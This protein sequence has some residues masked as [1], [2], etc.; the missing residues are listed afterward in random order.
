M[1][2]ISG[3]NVK[4][5]ISHLASA[6]L[7]VFEHHIVQ[8]SDFY[9]DILRNNW[10]NK[11]IKEYIPVFEWERSNFLIRIHFSLDLE[12]MKI[13]WMQQQECLEWE[14]KR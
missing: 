1:G 8:K 5:F 2:F 12:K 6:V 9:M 10:E 7:W 3:V 13:K 11:Y 4:L 14:I